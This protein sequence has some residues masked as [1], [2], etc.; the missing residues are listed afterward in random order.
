MRLKCSLLIKKKKMVNEEK[1][2]G[3]ISHTEGRRKKHNRPLAIEITWS[4][5][6]NIIYL[7][8]GLYSVC[9][10]IAIVL[11]GSITAFF[12]FKGIILCEGDN[13]SLFFCFAVQR[14]MLTTVISLPCARRKA[15]VH[16][17]FLGLRF[18]LKFLWH[19]DRQNRKTL[20][21]FRT[22]HM[23]WPG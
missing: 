9:N 17:T 20:L 7:L 22:K 3:K 6:F 16:R 13:R 12:K 21:S 14:C 15:F 18:C 4:A 2:K 8:H 10:Q 23:P 11:Q 19:F 1:K 5:V